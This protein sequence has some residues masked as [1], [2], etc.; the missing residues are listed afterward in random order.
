MNARSQVRS[1]L[2]VTNDDGIRSEGLRQLAIAATQSDFDVLVAAPDQESSGSSAAL[3]AVPAD[4]RIMISRTELAGL[5]GVHTVAVDAAPAFIV[6]AALHGAFGPVPELVV[7]GINRGPNTG[8]AVLHSGTVGAAMTAA[9]YGMRTAAF[10][11]DWRDGAQTH[12]DTAAVV[13]AELL[14]GLR[15]Q[16]PGVVLNVN[17]PNIPRSQLRGIRPAHSQRREPSSC[18]Y[19]RPHGTMCRSRYMNLLN[20]R[21]TAVMLRWSPPG[22]PVSRNCCLCAR[23]S[24]LY[25]PWPDRAS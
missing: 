11:L 17:V 13:A 22:S 20:G 19:W 14:P 1:S 5:P 25:R 16:R 4:G 8:R 15:S 2:L 21:L 12:W 6:F 9:P 23:S 10:S 24:G 3:S 7:S 18:R